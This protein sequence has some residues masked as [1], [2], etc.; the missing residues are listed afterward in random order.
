MTKAD[1]LKG[2]DFR[3]QPPGKR[4][5]D[6]HLGEQESAAD[7]GCRTAARIK[8]RSD[9]GGGA[10]CIAEVLLT[11]YDSRDWAIRFLRESKQRETEGRPG[12]RKR[13]KSS[14]ESTEKQ[15]RI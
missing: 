8:F 10:Y 4:V 15:M 11:F 13:K 7:E 12:L 9:S 5:K 1:R 14:V 6:S 3:K 2:E